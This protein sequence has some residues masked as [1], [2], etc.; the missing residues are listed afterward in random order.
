MADR[1]PVKRTG[2]SSTESG[3][4]NTSPLHEASGVLPK[5]VQAYLEDAE[6]GETVPGPQTPREAEMVLLVAQG[7]G[8]EEIAKRAGI[9]PKTVETHLGHLYARYGVTGRTELAMLAVGRGWI[10]VSDEG[11]ADLGHVE[12]RAHLGGRRYRQGRTSGPRAREQR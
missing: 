4:T 10:T 5:A 6:G 9:S 1:R 12:N 8:N 2:A 7:L 11:R 3:P